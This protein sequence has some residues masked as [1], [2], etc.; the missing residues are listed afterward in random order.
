MKKFCYY[1]MFCLIL[2]SC[3]SIIAPQTSSIR[4]ITTDN[5][6]VV[7]DSSAS[8]GANIVSNTYDSLGGMIQFDGIASSVGATA[9]HHSKITRILLPE[10][11]TRIEAGAFCFSE[12]LISIEIP[13]KVSYI[14]PGAF[15]GCHSLKEINIPNGLKN[16][17]GSSFI[18][19]AFESIILPEG[20]D[21]IGDCAFMH[22]QNLK[23]VNIPNTV[24]YIGEY[25]FYG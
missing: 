7:V 25:A 21:S 16:I 15:G 13:Q 24:S 5:A 17:K 20:I 6:I 18:G 23:H 19:C 11:I 8:F 3:K 14:G 2:L 22:C 9:F 12:K 4:Y 10:S 1:I